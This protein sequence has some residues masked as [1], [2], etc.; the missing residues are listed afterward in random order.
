MKQFKAQKYTP[1]R[2]GA[3]CALILF[4]ISIDA[5]NVVQHLLTVLDGHPDLIVDL[6]EI[7]PLTVQVPDPSKVRFSALLVE[8]LGNENALA[9]ALSVCG[10]PARPTSSLLHYEQQATYRRYQR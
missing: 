3:L 10:E 1:N 4:F 8:Q 9:V 7:L 6:N 5:L 2:P